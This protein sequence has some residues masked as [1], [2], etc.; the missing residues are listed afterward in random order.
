MLPFFDNPVPTSNTFSLPSWF[1]SSWHQHLPV[2]YPSAACVMSQ[3][4][5]HES[6]LSETCY[7]R[8]YIATY[9]CTLKQWFSNG[10][11][12]TTRFIFL[13]VLYFHF[14]FHDWLILGSDGL[15]SIYSQFEIKFDSILVTNVVLFIYFWPNCGCHVQQKPE[16]VFVTFIK[17]AQY[18]FH[19]SIMVG[20][21]SL[22]EVEE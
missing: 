8:T 9:S 11:K 20:G 17:A 1:S 13:L 10:G 22:P 15:K 14:V 12:R 21:E 2:H 18:C 4:F 6:N 5:N 7:M 19:L 3:H 16:I